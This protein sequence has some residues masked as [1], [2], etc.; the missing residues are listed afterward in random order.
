MRVS[1]RAV[2]EGYISIDEL[3]NA[4]IGSANSPCRPTVDQWAEQWHGIVNE[5]D[6]MRLDLKQY[7][8]DKQLID[9]VLNRDRYA[10]SHS[11]EYREAYNPHY[12]I[13]RR[14]IFEQEILPRLP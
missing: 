7:E 14:D 6:D 12:R 9:S 4:F 2:H 8:Q 1:L 5:M 3:L 10:L 11:P 13:V